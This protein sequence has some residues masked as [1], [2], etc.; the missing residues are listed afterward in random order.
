MFLSKF[1]LFRRM[2][3]FIKTIKLSFNLGVY[4]FSFS[5]NT[6]KNDY[7]YIYLQYLKSQMRDVEI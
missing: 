4:P 2:F 3:N 6:I 1:V 7:V 5:K